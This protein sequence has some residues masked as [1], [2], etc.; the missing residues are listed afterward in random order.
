MTTYKSFKKLTLTSQET[1]SDSDTK[2]KDVKNTQHNTQPSVSGV[3]HYLIP[4]KY[5]YFSLRL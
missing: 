1:N 3:K 4:S 2:K 5:F